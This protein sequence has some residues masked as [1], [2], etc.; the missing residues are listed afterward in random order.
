MSALTV[1]ERYLEPDIETRPRTGL[2][3]LQEER[4]L[5]MIPWAYERSPL[6]RLTWE[7]A[8]V[9]PADIETLEDFRARAPFISKDAVRD[10]RDRY[11][12]P[13]GG[14]LCVHP[15]E[16]RSVTSTSGTTG[17]ATF[18]AEQWDQWAP[19]AI[20][21]ARELWEAGLRPGT[22]GFFA[23]ATF[24]GPVYQGAQ[25]IGATPVLGNHLPHEADII[26]EMVR[27]H[28]PIVFFVM[29]SPLYVAFDHLSDKV[30]IREAFASVQTVVFSGEP[31][32]A[33]MK[34]RMAG[35]G[36]DTVIDY[37]SAGDAATSMECRESNGCHLPEDRLLAE[38]LDPSG[39]GPAAP[40]Q[41]GELVV[42]SLDNR[43]APLIRYRSED[44][45]R[46]STDTCGCG[47]TLARQW[48]CGRAGDDVVVDGHSVSVSDLFQAVESVPETAEAVFQL[49]RPQREM[50]VLRVRV[51]YDP[52]RS[53]DLGQLRDKVA[54]AIAAQVGVSPDIDLVPE[55]EI[56]SR[57]A[58]KIRRVTK[59]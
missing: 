40:G 13:Y 54:A 41:L 39:T 55:S 10:F 4:L 43:A 18:F 37:T 28:R 48:P 35:W 1:S 33:R 59:E 49:I 53:H 34:Q 36:M 16:L 11:G 22:R 56:L 58:N 7:T 23:G 42:T 51:G 27:R 38:H 29:T 5:E 24:R 19:M 6:T 17:D 30:D 8:G 20:N 57:S 14:L 31:R 3:A 46:F 15:S 26:I 47:R 45:I 12:D 44:L 25:I 21:I 9:K 50:T 52:S 32:S 2:V